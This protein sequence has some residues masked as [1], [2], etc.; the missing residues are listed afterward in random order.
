MKLADKTTLYLPTKHQH[1]ADIK[2]LIAEAARIAGG[3][4]MV[5]ARGS[6]AAVGIMIT[7]PVIMVTWWLES[8]SAEFY[9]P[10]ER[11]IKRLLSGVVDAEQAVMLERT[12]NDGVFMSG[13]TVAWLITLDE[14][15]ALS[16]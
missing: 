10:V 1:D 5:D 7:E 12:T 16:W 15:G 14:E 11:I 4:T 13:Q 8:W 9:S 3:C 6:Y 2:A